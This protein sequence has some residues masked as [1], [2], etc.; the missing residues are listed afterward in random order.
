[1][2]EQKLV[3]GR[4]N[5]VEALVKFSTSKSHICLVTG[6]ASYRLC[7]AGDFISASL[8]LC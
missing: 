6:G 1:M 2:S 5:A 7:G 4:E 8:R 3:V